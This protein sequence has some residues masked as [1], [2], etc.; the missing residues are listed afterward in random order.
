MNYYNGYSGSERDAKL[1]AQ[2]ARVSRGCPSHPQGPCAICGDRQVELEAHDEDYSQPYKWEPPAQYAVCHRCHMR[3]HNRF[4]NP[5]VWEAHK[6]HVRQGGR[7]NEDAKFNV[8]R[9]AIRGRDFSTLALSS[10]TR[11]MGHLWWEALSTD[12][13]TLHDPAARPRP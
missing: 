12:P 6:E 3:L 5:E 9:N 7:A 11:V 4:R 13:K 8:V 2:H 10:P 1:K